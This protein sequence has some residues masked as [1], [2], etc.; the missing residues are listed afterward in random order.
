M[1]YFNKRHNWIFKKEFHQNEFAVGKATH[2]NQ[3]VL[4]KGDQKIV[5]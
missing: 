5:S 3:Q 4:E 2:N 1:S